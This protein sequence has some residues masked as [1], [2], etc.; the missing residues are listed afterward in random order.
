MTVTIQSNQIIV[1]IAEKGAELQSIRNR[2][3]G[4]EYL[5]QGDKA[6]WNR[7]AP[8]LFPIVGRLKDNR[9][10][11]QGKDYTLNQHGFA[12]DQLF[13]LVE[14]T[15]TSA[16]FEL[17][18]NAETRKHYPFDFSLVIAY[19]VIEQQV[20][21]TYE[22]RN[23]HDTETLFYS[24]GGHPAFN[25]PLTTD[26]TFDDYYLDFYPRRSRIQIP[27][28]G[29]YADPAS[30]TLVQTNTPFQLKRELFEKDALIFETKG[31]STFSIR[32]DKTPHSIEVTFEDYPYVGIWS[33]PDKAAPFVCIEPW[34]GI[35][36][37]VDANGQLD[38]KLGIRRL[39]PLKTFTTS[40]HIQ[41]H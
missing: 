33:V 40:Y 20:T 5:W 26:T 15:K 30:K 4:M 29:P 27:L 36:D 8:V 31:K 38:E 13:S 11:Y 39:L 35:A 32:S 21:V 10:T 19:A 37:T 22:V 12:R 2:D 34:H 9:Y 1:N 16:R 7:K 25:V 6:Y 3:T 18:S 41:L 14:Q 24:V 17:T 28:K 23:L